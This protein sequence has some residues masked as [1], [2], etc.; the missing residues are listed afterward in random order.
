LYLAPYKRSSG[1]KTKG[2]KRGKKNSRKQKIETLN[3]PLRGVTTSEQ[4]SRA[5]RRLRVSFFRGVFVHDALPARARCDESGIVNLDDAAGTHWVAYAKR[6]NNA[7][8][9]NEFGIFDRRGSSNDI[10]ETV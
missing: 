6:G 7:I 2:A 1:A 3:F 9:F 8:Y 4:L 10:L 5:A